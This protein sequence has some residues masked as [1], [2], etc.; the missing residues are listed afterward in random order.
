MVN[1]SS[2]EAETQ[3][4]MAAFRETQDRKARERMVEGYNLLRGA[5]AWF[6]SHEVEK[7]LGHVPQWVESGRRLT[8][9]R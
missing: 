8:Q 1:N 6:D 5:L 3:A 9:G 7:E 4:S 2:M